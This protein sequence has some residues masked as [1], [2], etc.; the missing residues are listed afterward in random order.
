MFDFSN[1]LV[2]IASCLLMG[3]AFGLVAFLIAVQ[4]KARGLA[5]EL[6]QA[7]EASRYSRGRPGGLV[8]IEQN[9][10]SG[11]ALHYI[12]AE[13]RQ[14]VPPQRRVPHDLAHRTQHHV[15]PISG[16]CHGGVVCKPPQ[17]FWPALWGRQ[18]ASQP[19]GSL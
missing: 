3:L 14:L 5:T 10:D 17:P 12:E 7:G 6:S 9:S 1:P 16:Y 11:A 18:R 8:G 2:L 15:Q 4:L 13:E 19:C